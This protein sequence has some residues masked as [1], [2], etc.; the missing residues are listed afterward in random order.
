MILLVGYRGNMGN[1]YGKILDYLGI[2][3][4]GVDIDDTYVKQRTLAEQASG[5]LIAS[6]TAA[7]INHLHRF[8][9]MGKPVLC[10]KPF[11]KDL[12]AC[13][14]VLD[15]YQKTRTPLSMV[16][17][18]AELMPEEPTKGPSWYN[19]YKTGKDGLVWDCIQIIALS[20]KPPEL[21]A[22]SPI[23]EC[24]I[25]GHRLSLG[26]MDEAYVKNVK[27][28]LDGD[29]MNLRTI[30][31]AHAKTAQFEAACQSG[32][33]D[34]STQYVGEIAGKITRRYLRAPN[35]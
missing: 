23:W 3:W 28:W 18:Y 30:Y 26:D 22:R 8:A 21:Q 32:D 20:K 7:H 2:K 1:R 24:T 19:Y 11:S 5:I 15:L 29:Y 34:S 25:N 10:E 35:G 17:Q 31:D 33:R 6:P 12:T 16:F 9:H 4:D 27:R 13:A 14:E